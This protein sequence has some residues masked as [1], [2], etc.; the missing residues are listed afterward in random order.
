MGYTQRMEQLGQRLG[1]V[2]AIRKE[3]G[4][5]AT[6]FEELAEE[7]LR[8]RYPKPATERDAAA[9]QRHRNEPVNK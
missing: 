2:Q 1:R 7:R 6:K 5:H 4:L 9:L 8:R 3:S